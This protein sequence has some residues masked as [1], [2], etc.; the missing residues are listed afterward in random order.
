MACLESG[1]LESG[2][3]F[4]RWRMSPPLTLCDRGVDPQARSRRASTNHSMDQ[5][6]RSWGSGSIWIDVRH[7]QEKFTAFF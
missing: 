4:A 6:R 1:G 5:Q 7:A 2:G 3:S